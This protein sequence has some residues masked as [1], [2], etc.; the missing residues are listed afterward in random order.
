MSPHPSLGSSKARLGKAQI[1]IVIRDRSRLSVVPESLTEREL[2]MRELLP[3]LSVL[4]EHRLLGLLPLELSLEV[5]LLLLLR[6]R[7]EGGG[8]GKGDV[9]VV[10]VVRG[11]G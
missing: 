3:L 7:E 4:H 8:E 9:V 1:E 11:L 10:R 2:V 6:V 5:G